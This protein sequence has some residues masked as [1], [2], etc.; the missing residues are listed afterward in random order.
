MSA[1]KEYDYLL[2]SGT[3]LE[4]FP[5]L[6]GNWEKDKK[7]FVPNWERNVKAIKE[8]DTTYEEL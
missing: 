1:K 2:E 3:L 6:K 5:G 4:L 8:I 7:F